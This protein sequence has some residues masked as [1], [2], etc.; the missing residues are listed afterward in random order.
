MARGRQSADS[1][2][3]PCMGGQGYGSCPH[4]SHHLYGP[5]ISAGG[6]DVRTRD[7]N[8][9]QERGRIW[10]WRA[11]REGTGCR[12]AGLHC[13][14]TASSLSL[15]LSLSRSIS[16]SLSLSLSPVLALS[17]SRPLSLSLAL[18]RSRSLSCSLS[19][20]LSLAYQLTDPFTPAAAWP[21]GAFLHLLFEP[22]VTSYETSGQLGHDEPD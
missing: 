19:L 10:A 9:V 22:D 21:C 14:G 11:R 16:L 7:L 18:A 17:L 12:C 15:S 20:A 3:L 13:P 4:S 2:A 8:S 5:C 6:W 1:A